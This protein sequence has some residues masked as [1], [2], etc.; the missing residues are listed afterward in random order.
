MQ[1]RDIYYQNRQIL[2]RLGIPLWANRSSITASMGKA[3]DR[4]TQQTA[5]IQPSP[6]PPVKLA[7]DMPINPKSALSTSSKTAPQNPKQ[8]IDTLLKSTAK[9]KVKQPPSSAKTDAPAEFASLEPTLQT[10]KIEFHLQ[11]MIYRDWL[12]L[13]NVDTLDTAGRELWLSL[14]QA[15]AKQARQAGTVFLNKALNYPLFADDANADT[16]TI[17]VANTTVKGF[18]FGCRR[19]VDELNHIAVLSPLPDFLTLDQMYQIT[20][21]KQ[22]QISDM[23]IQAAIKK[24]F[25]QAIHA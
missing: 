25:W 8:I 11:A 16:N 13:V 19:A 14:N 7:D 10:I 15:I 12:I 22:Y 3:A 20:I 2:A 21:H 5:I 4:T 24:Q 23:L 9:T 17:S 1:M 18:V 6:E